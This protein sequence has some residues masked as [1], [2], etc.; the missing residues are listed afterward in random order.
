MS[1]CLDIRGSLY[2]L[3][4]VV[5]RSPVFFQ[6]LV[7]SNDYSFIVLRVFVYSFVCHFT[8]YIGGKTAY[9]CFFRHSWRV[10][11]T[12]SSFY[13]C[14]FRHSCVTLPPI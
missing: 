11:I 3:Y 1:V 9:E 4:K 12:H 6:T 2:H 8:T 10:M 7:E 13:E 5:K 14:L